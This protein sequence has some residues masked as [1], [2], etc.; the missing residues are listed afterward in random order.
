MK[1]KALEIAHKLVKGETLTHEDRTFL[2][3]FIFFANEFQDYI[4]ETKTSG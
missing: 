4:K 3:A 1:T 2:I